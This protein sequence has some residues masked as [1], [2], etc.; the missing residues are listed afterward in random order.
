MAVTGTE[1]STVTDA[2]TSISHILGLC[3]WLYAYT[4]LS[5]PSN[6]LKLIIHLLDH[7]SCLL[8]LLH[9]HPHSPLSPLSQTQ[10]RKK[11]H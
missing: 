3:I 8:Q 5:S 2:G 9:S 11:Y 4:Q 7:H 1:Y 6:I 10:K